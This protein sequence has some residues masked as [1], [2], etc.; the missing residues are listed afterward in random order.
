LD[1]NI[2]CVVQQTDPVSVMLY[3]DCP[4]FSLRSV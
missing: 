2:V 1:L 4:L 3:K